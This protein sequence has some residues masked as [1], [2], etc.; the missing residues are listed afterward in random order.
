[1]SKYKLIAL[2]LDNTLLT[3]DKTITENTKYWLNRARN[4]GITII[5]CTGRGIQRTEAF[6]EELNL[7]TPMVLVNGAE[8]WEKPGKLMERHVLPELGVR[9]LVDFAD[10]HNSRYWGYS[11]QSLTHKRDWT[12][13]S[14]KEDWLK[15][16]IRNDDIPTIDRLRE[17]VRSWG[18]YEVT[19]S[20]AVNMEISPLG[21][22]K[23]YG[24]ELVCKHL[25]I[26]L[27]QV[28]AMGDSHN[29]STMLKKAGLGVAMANASEEIKAMA[30]V[31]TASNEDDGVAKAI[32][33]YVF[34]EQ[35]G[36]S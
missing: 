36:V 34:G 18:S 19:Q 24:L 22:N 35:W 21:I 27:D 17:E 15:F 31:V 2:D 29:D 4:E 28:I 8:I 16:G 7:E 12:E 10:K 14:F 13:A 9:E 3:D 26:T 32:E 30:D 6:W 33:Q 11:V 1:M 20:H 25:G 23:G 5:F